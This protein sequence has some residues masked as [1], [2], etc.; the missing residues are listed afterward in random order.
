MLFVRNDATTDE[1]AKSYEAALTAVNAV[2]DAADTA[3][4]GK[5]QGE[6]ASV[7]AA[8]DRFAAGYRR[9]VDE[10]NDVL[11][12]ASARAMGDLARFARDSLLDANGAVK[13][14]LLADLIDNFARASDEAQKKAKSYLLPLAIGGAAVAALVLALAIGGRK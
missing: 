14:S 7:K 11:R 3:L 2:V 4:P 13:R 9:G 10:K 6:V 12:K 1:T 8:R 5:R